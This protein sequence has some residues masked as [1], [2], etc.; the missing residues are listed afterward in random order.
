MIQLTHRGVTIVRDAGWEA[1][2]RTFADRHMI[3]LPQFVEGS[4]LD[5]VVR[6]FAKAEFH[7]LRHSTGSRELA[8]NDDAPVSWLFWL[9]LNRPALFAAMQELVDGCTARFKAR[10]D[11]LDEQ[12]RSFEIGRCF[13]LVPGR[14][15][16]QSWH[17]DVTEGRLVGLSVNLGEGAGGLDIRHVRCSAVRRATPAFGSAVLFR[18]AN[19][20]VHRGFLAEGNAPRCAFSGWFTDRPVRSAALRGAALPELS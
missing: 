5:R 19:G 20:L 8:T 18:I 3:V 10:K 4:L 15:H 12:V 2:K 16:R 17:T 14:D 13:K 9:L 11:V 1:A 6:L 7:E